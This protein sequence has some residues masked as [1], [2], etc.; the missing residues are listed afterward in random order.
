[1]ALRLVRAQGI[2]S[3]LQILCFITHTHTH[4]HMHIHTY[5]NAHLPPPPPP[6]PHT[7]THAGMHMIGSRGSLPLQGMLGHK[8]GA[9]WPL[10]QQTDVHVFS[11]LGPHLLGPG[12][13][14]GPV[15]AGGRGGRSCRGLSASGLDPRPQGGQGH[16]PHQLGQHPAPGGSPE[17]RHCGHCCRPGRH[18]QAAR[19]ALYPRQPLRCQGWCKAGWLGKVLLVI[20]K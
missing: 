7:F 3:G 16:L 5:T 2:Y 8:V 18:Q 10:G 17:R 13:H 15:L 11:S 19:L 4:T 9:S 14:G 20:C 12:Q 6:T 1:M